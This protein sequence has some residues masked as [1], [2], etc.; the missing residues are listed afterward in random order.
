MRNSERA[1]RKTRRRKS[2]RKTIKSISRRKER[3][4]ISAYR[5]TKV[6]PAVWRS[7]FDDTTEAGLRVQ[8]VF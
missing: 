2:F 7:H 1:E 4:S 3:L 6:W 5:D 8:L